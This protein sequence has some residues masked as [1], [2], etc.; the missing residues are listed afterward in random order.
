[1]PILEQLISTASLI[2]TVWTKPASISF[3]TCLRPG[4]T[5]N[6]D[7]TCEVL[8]SSVGEVQTFLYIVGL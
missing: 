2:K 1:M 3:Y 7:R 8:T 5:G 6:A 4:P